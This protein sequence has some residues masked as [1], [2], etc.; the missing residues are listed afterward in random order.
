MKYNHR[1]SSYLTL[2][3]MSL[4]V[5][6][7]HVLHRRTALKRGVRDAFG[8]PM[9]VLLAGMVAYG[10]VAHQ[11]G[12][13]PWVTSLGSVFIFALPGQVVMQEMVI[14]GAPLI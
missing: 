14:A 1:S 9:L 8:S 3:V 5:R 12:F 4:K 6:L 7:A 11:Q 2:F 13:D 10:S